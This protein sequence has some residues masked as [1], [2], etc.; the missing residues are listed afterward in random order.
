[1]PETLLQTNRTSPGP[2]LCVGEVLVDLIAHDATKWQDITYFEPRIGGAPANA[3]VAIKRLG[4]NASFVG[5]ISGDEPG[6]WIRQR[7]E[8]EGISLDHADTGS[9]GQTRLAVVTGPAHNRQFDFYGHPAADT[10]LIPE[11]IDRASVSAASAVMFGSLL[12]LT[13]SSKAAIHHLLEQANRHNVPIVFDPNPR[14]AMWPDPETTRNHLIPIIKQAKM[15]KLGRDELRLLGMTA[16][17]IR[18][19]QPADSIL[20]ITDGAN[21][22]LY[23]YGEIEARQIAPFS[24]DSVDSTGAGDSFTASLLLR[25]VS[26]SGA[27]DDDDIRF[28]SACGALTTTRVGAMD[29]LPTLNEVEQVLRSNPE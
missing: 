23:W 15:L 27:I 14:P 2:V 18:A 28:A 5:C 19:E 3:A 7:L 13:E 8:S 29:A 17:Q 16:D 26:N 4:G 25:M 9:P 6:R 1:M 21:G 20:A 10:L 22:C 24:V 11:H 12:L